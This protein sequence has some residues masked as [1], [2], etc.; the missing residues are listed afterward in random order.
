MKNI[1]TLLLATGVSFAATAQFSSDPTKVTLKEAPHCGFQQVLEKNRV[2]YSEL[3]KAYRSTRKPDA[4]SMARAT[5]IVYDIPVVVHVVYGPGQQGLNLHDSIIHNQIRILNDAF[6]KRHADTGNVRSMFR[7][8]SKD[9]EIQF[10]LATKDPSGNPTTGITR[11]L[12]TRTYF[13]SP[14]YS[15]DSLE[16]IKFTSQGGVDPWPVGRYM[17]VWICNLSDAQGQLAVLGYAVPPIPLPNNNWPAGA[18]QELALLRDGVVLQTHS[19]GS[20]NALSAQ[21]LGLYTKGRCA[22]H[23]VGHYL[24]LQHIFGSNSGDPSTA[25]CGLIADDG[26]ADTPPQSTISFAPTCPDPAKNSCGAGEPGDLPDMWENYMDYTKDACQGLF[27]N[28]QIAIMRSVLGDQRNSL[29]N[30]VSVPEVA[31]RQNFALYPNPAS[32]QLFAR[33]PGQIEK[34]AVVNYLG[35]KVLQWEGAAAREKNYDISTLA[36]GY[37]LLRME[38]DGQQ[39]AEKFSIAR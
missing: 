26:I 24:G 16:R 3:I 12:S 36:P 25:D 37:Y 4:A 29:F 6:R 15:F 39:L 23:E 28:G 19:V 27:T 10:H 2:Q 17:N 7:P 33:Y 30:S 8:L 22:V 1:L 9:A 31:G 21:L 5:G 35:Q 20:N 32:Q 11:T 14:D 34:A 38:S 13:G 18:E